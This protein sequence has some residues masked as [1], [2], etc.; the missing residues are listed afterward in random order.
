MD[1]EL[2]QF[3]KSYS[4]ASICVQGVY[5]YA[6]EPGSSGRQ[7]TAPFRGFIFPISGRAQYAFDG[8]LYT[9]DSRKIIHGVPDMMLDKLVLGNRRWE[10]ISVFYDITGK[11]PEGEFLPDTHF[12][13]SVG[14]SP[15]LTGLLWRL[16]R[17]FS[18]PGALSSFQS[19][20]LF[21]CILEEMFLSAASQTSDSSHMLFKSVRS[22]IHDYYMEGLT[23]GGLAEQNGVTANR[24]FYVFR[25]YAGMGPG[26]YL[27]RYRLNRAKEIL[28]TS[29]ALISDVAR[30]VGYDDPLYFSRL[31]KKQFG[32]TPSGFR[33][34]F[35]NNPCPS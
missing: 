29:D 15:R 30:G 9:T 19:E 4:N 2:E 24:L 34:K 21:R 5:H 8:T 35:R 16:R 33:E 14:H 3:I 26:D 18:E 23:V 17:V 11:Q 31:F 25:S 28:I 12:E 22:Y 6:I 32:I 20:V 27:L 13:L 7:K 1:A 10:Y